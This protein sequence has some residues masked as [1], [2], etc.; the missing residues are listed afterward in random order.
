MTRICNPF[1]YGDG[2]LDSCF[3]AET[4]PDTDRPP[5]SGDAQTEVAVVGAGVTG[6]NAALHLAEAGM[7]V[8]VL[9]AEQVGWGASGRNG[10]FCC[11]GGAKASHRSLKRR[12]GVAALADYQQAERAA[13][14]HVEQL[15]SRLDLD[16]DRHSEGET[17]LAHTARAAMSFEDEA[18]DFERAY[19][20]K[21]QV[22]R[23]PDL[24]EH[25]LGA[26]FHGALNLPIGF[27][28]N[29]RKYLNGVANAA[30]AAGVVLYGDTPVV[31]TSQTNGN[32]FLNTPQGC[33]TAK[34]LVIATNGYSSE[35]VPPWLSGRYL[36]AQSS[37][38][39]TRP[40]TNEE[41]HAQ[42][43]TSHQMAY[44]SRNLLH[45]FR[46]MPDR[47]FLFGMRGGLAT[48]QHAHEAIH[49]RIMREF[50]QLFPAWS[51]V[52]IPH[53]WGGFVCYSRGL[54]PFAG[55][56]PGIDGLYAAFAY[57]GNGVGMGSYAGALLA[58]DILGAKSL[59]YPEIMRATPRR[60]PLGRARRLLMYPA[61]LYYALKDL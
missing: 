20:L 40:L 2:P 52:D 9:D 7:S 27:A 11:L 49:L 59:R 13:V 30:E 33:L 58:Q 16:V 61:Y 37:V 5:L 26:T 22:L 42:N 34:K 15:L 54:T 45:Y 32:W 6:L 12:F 17:Q 38:I 35:H 21:A 28:L 1:A 24:P 48:S 39:V 56:V 3:W 50:A 8:T 10:G 43:W 47:R 19:G 51:H 25:G 31:A 4:V 57:H 46:L 41:L 53:F 14:D 60:F 36:P 18:A 29:P 44:D 55:A 23:Q